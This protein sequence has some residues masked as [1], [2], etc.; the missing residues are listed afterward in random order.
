MSWNR[1][2]EIH[3][4]RATWYVNKSQTPVYITTF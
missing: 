1:A 4:F 3:F 2:E